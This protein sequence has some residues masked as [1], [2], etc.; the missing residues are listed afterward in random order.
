MLYLRI[1]HQNACAK[2]HSPLKL[3]LI[4]NDCLSVVFSYYCRYDGYRM[5]NA[6]STATMIFSLFLWH[7]LFLIK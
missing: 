3:W 6:S 5:S 2:S 1:K 4:V 7:S